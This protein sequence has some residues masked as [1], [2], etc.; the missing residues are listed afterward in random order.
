MKNLKEMV[1]YCKSKRFSKKV[2]NPPDLS[3]LEVAC[4]VWYAHW[5]NLDNLV[6]IV[7]NAHGLWANSDVSCHP[8]ING[9]QRYG[10]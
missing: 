7:F 5:L 1:W 6:D 10:S 2:S 3:G 8:E 4:C 9:G